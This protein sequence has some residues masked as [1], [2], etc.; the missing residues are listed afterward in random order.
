MLYLVIAVALCLLV[1]WLPVLMYRRLPR[2]P[3]PPLSEGELHRLARGLRRTTPPEAVDEAVLEDDWTDT[4][5]TGQ[6]GSLPAAARRSEKESETGGESD[7]LHDRGGDGSACQAP[8]RRLSLGSYRW[9]NIVMVPLIIITFLLLAVCW[10]ALLQYLGEEHARSFPPAVFLF[11]PFA[12]G[13]VCAVPGLFLGIFS[14]IPLLTLIARLIMGRRRF[15]E[16][17]YWDEG[18]LGPGHVEGAIRMIAGLA[19]FV[20]ILSALFVGLVMNWYA[21]FTEEEIAIKRL[22]GFGEEVHPYSSVDQIVVTS[23]IT[24]GKEVVP[25]H[26][27]GLRFSDGRTWSTDQTFALPRDAA[28]RERLLEFL[29]R[30]T[31]KPITRVRLLKDAPGW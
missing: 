29:R 13:I 15:L 28:E 16:Y 12:Y 14:S 3:P 23:H 10:S 22:L 30:K 9:L 27:L 11:K 26:D 6:P 5:V 25:G 1:P 2:R 19:L 7:T 24:Q 17:L 18:R 8:A 31:G 20:G 4:D 21:R